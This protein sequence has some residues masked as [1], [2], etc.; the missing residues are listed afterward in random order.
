MTGLA[1]K[2]TDVPWQIL[3]AVAAMVTTGVTPDVTF[4]VMAL[5]LVTDGDAQLAVDVIWQV[6]T[7]P[8]FKLVLLHVLLFVPTLP[9]FNFH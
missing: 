3:V 5:E 8:L 9:P 7:S 2:L 1:V 6:I 4:M